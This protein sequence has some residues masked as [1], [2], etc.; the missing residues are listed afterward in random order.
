MLIEVGAPEHLPAFNE[1]LTGAKAGEQR[2]FSVDYPKEYEH[3]PLAGQSVRYRV[4]VHE[5]KRKQIP[6]LDDEFAKDLGDFADLAALR[7][8]V[9]DD[10]LERRRQEIE[11][12]VRQSVLDKVLLEN[13]IVL[14][15][16]LVEHEVRH[17][18]ESIVRNM[19][20][21]GVDPEKVQLDWEKLRTEQEEPARKSVHARLILDRVAEVESLS[22]DTAE[23][24]ERIR[25]DAQRI[26]EKPDKLRRQL[27][28]RGGLE[29]L[30]A[31]L[32]REKSLD[33]LR[34]V[35]NIQNEE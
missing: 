14:P 30:K 34:A 20:L 16:V 1:Q 25:R 24:E 5:V 21:Q 10:L 33:L 8:R 18:L 23:V 28:K 29:G 9:R 6:D 32:V 13:P 31:Q 12:G 27:E 15:D 22:I 7:E 26:G 11:R 2:E 3:P 4:V 19:I 35:A 17:R